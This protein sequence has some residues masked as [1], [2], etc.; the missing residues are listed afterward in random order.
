MSDS[1]YETL[2]SAY[3]VGHRWLPSPH[4]CFSFRGTFCFVFVLVVDAV[5]TFRSNSLEVLPST[6]FWTEAFVGW[7][8][9]S[10]LSPPRCL[11][12]CYR[13]WVFSMYSIC[14]SNF[15]STHAHSN[16]RRRNSYKK[17]ALPHTPVANPAPSR[18]R[19]QETVIQGKT[20][21]GQSR[22]SNRSFHTKT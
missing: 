15:A 19:C 7:S 1:P 2:H 3:L 5:G 16:F 20:F 18:Q 12:R 6:A 9:V 22:V 21:S 11:P 10:S 13:G 4:R 8:L 17:S 14:P